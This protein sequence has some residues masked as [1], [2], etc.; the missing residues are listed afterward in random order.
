MLVTKLL[1]TNFG[2]RFKEPK[3]FVSNISCISKNFGPRKLG[4]KF[5]LVN[6]GIGFSL[7]IKS[8]LPTKLKKFVVVLVYR[9][10]T[11]TYR[12]SESIFLEDG[13]A[14]MPTTKN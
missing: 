12:V 9:F 6:F 8:L 3:H 4:S 11:S 10:N 7:H 5:F 1:S 2:L 13:W 14:S